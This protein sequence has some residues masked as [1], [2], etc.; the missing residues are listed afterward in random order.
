MYFKSP[1]KQ[2]QSWEEAGDKQ[3]FAF[4]QK[5]SFYYIL[6]IVAYNTI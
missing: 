6:F 2:A 3:A 5:F 4:M 1:E